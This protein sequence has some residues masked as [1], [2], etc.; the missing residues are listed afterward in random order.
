MVEQQAPTWFI[1]GLLGIMCGV[2]WFYGL[3]PKWRA[4]FHRRGRS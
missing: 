2:A 3:T 1:L 4:R